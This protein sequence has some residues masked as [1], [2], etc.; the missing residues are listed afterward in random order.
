MTYSEGSAP[1][2]SGVL[3]RPLESVERLLHR[4]P[5]PVVALK[6]ICETHR[7]GELLDRFPE[8]RAIWIFRH[9]QDAVISAS[10]KW[11]SG[12]EAVRRLA[13]GELERA[14]WRAGG[15]S[16]EKL[17]TVRQLYRDDLSLHAANAIMWYLRND[18]Y[19]DLGIDQR[20]DV[21]LVRYEDIVADPVTSLGRIFAFA[22]LGLPADATKVV[23]SS[24][25]NS[26]RP[27]P[28]IPGEIQLLC[29]SVELKLVEQYRVTLTRTRR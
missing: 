12:K 28:S 14:G 26:K 5:F 25:S 22:G 19:F 9:Y 8:S 7:I 1:F 15:L 6:P 29:E 27:F 21:L 18:L 4:N 2:F 10:T 23:R 3:L 17:A 11:R 13:S 20:A 16:A 24:P